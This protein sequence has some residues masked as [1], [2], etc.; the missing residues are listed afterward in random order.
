[1]PALDTAADNDRRARISSMKETSRAALS[2]QTVAQ[3][4]QARATKADEWAAWWHREMEI[5]N[6]SN[7]TELLPDAFARLEQKAEDLVLS[8]VRQLK[9]DLRKAIK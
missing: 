5:N 3:R 7:P 6:S 2:G 9:S 8:A 4:E 1:M